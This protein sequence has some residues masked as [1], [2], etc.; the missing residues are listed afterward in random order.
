MKV[1]TILKTFKNGN[2]EKSYLLEL[3]NFGLKY[4]NHAAMLNGLTKDIEIYDNV[5]TALDNL[6]L[7]VDVNFL[8]KFQILK[9][10]TFSDE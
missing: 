8:Q 9:V 4:N 2:V 6:S 3:D 5:Y 10:N 1:Y 7:A